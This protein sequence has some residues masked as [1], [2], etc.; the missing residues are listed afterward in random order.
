MPTC[1]QAGCE[2]G[3][4]LTARVERACTR[5]KESFLVGGA[6]HGIPQWSLKWA[7]A[8]TPGFSN[9]RRPGHWHPLATGCSRNRWEALLH[10]QEQKTL[11]TQ[12]S[13]V[14]LYWRN[15]KTGELRHFKIRPPDW[16][17]LSSPAW[18]ITL[19]SYLVSLTPAFLLPGWPKSVPKA[20]AATSPSTPYCWLLPCLCKCWILPLHL[21]GDNWSLMAQLEAVSL[22]LPSLTTYP[23]GNCFLLSMPE[24]FFPS[25]I[26]SNRYCDYLQSY[27]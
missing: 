1:S 21:A 16:G 8:C 14:W 15:E 19:A 9:E 23:K 20:L 2:L 13:F 3:P 11:G 22:A 27:L 5:E 24:T 4:L 25:L 10:C 7:R 17:V 18:I 6:V 26:C 12:G